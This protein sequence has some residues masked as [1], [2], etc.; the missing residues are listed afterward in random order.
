MFAGR[1]VESGETRSRRVQRIRSIGVTSKDVRH[2]SLHY[3]FSPFYFFYFFLWLRRYF[4]FKNVAM[5]FLDWRSNLTHV[6]V[7]WNLYIIPGQ[8]WTLW[9]T[10]GV[11]VE[12]VEH[13]ECTCTSSAESHPSD[14][15]G[16]EF[17]SQN[18]W[19]IFELTLFPNLGCAVQGSTC[20]PMSSTKRKYKITFPVDKIIMNA[21]YLHHITFPGYPVRSTLWV[22]AFQV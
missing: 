10:D 8:D 12:E 22:F 15:K 16:N 11:N 13:V 20:F 6:K 21:S 17:R 1:A 3:S 5:I 2:P 18:K 19:K 7:D 14:W 9:W 4:V